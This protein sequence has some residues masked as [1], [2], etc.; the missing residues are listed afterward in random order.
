MIRADAEVARLEWT[1]KLEALDCEIAA[2][3]A[4]PKFKG[5]GYNRFA[6]RP[7]PKEWEQHLELHDGTKV[8]M[9]PVRPEDEDMLRAFLGRITAETGSRQEA[10]EIDLM[11][12]SILAAL[13]RERPADA[14]VAYQLA[15]LGAG[16]GRW[17]AG[18]TAG[19]CKVRLVL[20]RRRLVNL[21]VSV[22]GL[23]P[24]PGYQATGTGQNCF[25]VAQVGQRRSRRARCSRP[26]R[27]A[28][29]DRQQ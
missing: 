12:K 20:I 25:A 15:S 11:A 7:Y 2:P 5:P 24:R 19:T 1:A 29:R 9:R 28:R 8:F 16:L 26:V 13:A 22:G 27:P 18:K 21:P 6:V 14:R 4:E 3:E 10:V 17:S 23:R